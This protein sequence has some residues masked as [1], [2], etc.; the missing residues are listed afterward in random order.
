MAVVHMTLQEIAKRANV[1]VATVSRTIHRLPTVNPVLARRVR[2]VI[3]KEGYYP[4]THARA[5]VSGRSRILGLIISEISNPFFPEIVETFAKLGVQHNYEVI[6]TSIGQDPRV[7]EI[8][9]RQMIERR[10]DGIAILTFGGDDALIDMFNSRN[11]PVF[12]VDHDCPGPLLRTVRIDYEHGIREAVQHLAA[13]GHVRIAFIGGP[14]HLRTAAMRRDAFKGCMKEIGLQV[15]PELLVEGDHTMQA[16]VKAISALAWL[17]D[18]PTAVVCSNDLTA[19]G[20]MRQA[21]ELS[22]NIPRDLSVVGFDDIPLAQFMIP[23]LTTVQMSQIG[24]ASLAFSALLNSAEV[25][26]IDTHLVL[27]CSTTLA[28]GRIRTL[29]GSRG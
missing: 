7:L 23:S 19:I 13:L 15:P 12:A 17:P 29:Q 27:R 2:R 11:V 24:I 3:E 9:A 6:L 10:V 20:V 26:S 14:A 1:S 22:L 4:N 25:Q 16:G 18:R 21:F 8:A 28:P 5:L